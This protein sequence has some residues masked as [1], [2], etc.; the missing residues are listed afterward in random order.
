VRLNRLQAG[1]PQALCGCVSR[2]GIGKVQ[3]Q[4]LLGIDF[5]RLTRL[6]DLEGQRRV[7]QAED[8]AVRSVTAFEGL[9]ER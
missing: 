5:D 2:H 6:N 8:G 9:D 4:L 7:G 3:A 1:R